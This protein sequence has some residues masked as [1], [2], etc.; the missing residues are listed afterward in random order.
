MVFKSASSER[1]SLEQPNTV[2][3]RD[4]TVLP[5]A[6]SILE[7]TIKLC[8]HRTTTGKIN[9]TKMFSV[10]ADKKKVTHNSTVIKKT[11]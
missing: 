6:I 8:E 7:R 3:V 5:D 4:E 1:L 9:V 11:D 2:T 10:E